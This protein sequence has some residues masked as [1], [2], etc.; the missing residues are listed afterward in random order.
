MKKM[1]RFDMFVPENAADAL[2]YIDTHQTGVHL[3]ANG[4]DLINRIQRKQITP[5]VLVDLTGLHE[6]EYVRK[7][8]GTIRIGA[9]TTISELIASPIINGRYDVFREVAAKFGGPSIINMAT[10]GGNICSASSSEDLIPVLL[11]LDAE[12]LVRSV[13]GERTIPLQSFVDGKRSTGLKSNE[14]MVE[15][16]FPE[17]DDRS[18]CGFEKIGMRNSLIIAFV[19]CA[20]YL[21]LEPKS[22]RADEVRVAF[23]RVSGKIPQRATETEKKL[24]GQELNERS[25]VAGGSV[26]REELKLTSDFRVSEEYRLEVACAVFKRVLLE[27]AERLSGEK[28]IV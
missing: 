23:N 25:I 5:K 28:V 8:N 1:R 4:T 17:L 16:R 19:N 13:H 20:I 14:M 7:E 10:V 15:T 12:V 21:K 18:T 22:S 11:V 9:L 24:K 27:C 26:L 2:Q 6:L 3:I